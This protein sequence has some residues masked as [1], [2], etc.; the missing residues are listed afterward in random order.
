ME[1]PS[2]QEGG[3]GILRAPSEKQTPCLQESC[4]AETPG[5]LL[6]TH[7]L[8]ASQRDKKGPLKSPLDSSFTPKDRTHW[9][10]ERDLKSQTI[11]F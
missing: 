3:R 5:S 8:L 9:H 4:L 11:N 7:T 1:A 2:G 10:L 6:L